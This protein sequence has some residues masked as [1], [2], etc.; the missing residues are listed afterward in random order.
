MVLLTAVFSS[1]GRAGPELEIS[2]G[3]PRGTTWL[4]PYFTQLDTSFPGDAFHARWEIHR[5]QCADVLI[6]SEETYPQGIITGEQL[7]VGGRALLTRGFEKFTGDQRSL[8]DSPLLM[9]QLLFALVQKSVPD[10]PAGLE[11]P[12]EIQYS[13]QQHAIDLD[14]GMAHGRFAA[15]WQLN[16]EIHRTDDGSHRFDLQFEFQVKIDDQPSQ[17]SAIRLT[18]LLDYQVRKFPV[19]DDL[20]LQGWSIL[21]MQTE[22]PDRFATADINKLEELR[23]LVKQ[24]ESQ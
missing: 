17:S 22:A 14:T 5:C 23:G 21:D 2:E 4:Q 9:L 7:L 18:G 3:I 24:A 12:T 19:Q 16:G 13:E 8:L 20:S 1:T 6:R 10:G 11:G 15:P